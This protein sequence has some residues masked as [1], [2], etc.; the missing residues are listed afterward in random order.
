MA[1]AATA[2]KIGFDLVSPE[3]LLLS[4]DV[5][6]VEIPAE[7]GDIGVLAGHAPMIV[8]LR[9]GIIRIHEGGEVTQRLFVSGGFCE[10]TPQR[11]TVLA[12]EATP[13][14]E[15]DRVRAEARVKEAEAAY[16]A[17]ARADEATREAAFAR[18]LSAQAMVAAAGR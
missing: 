12:D 1:Q 6:L 11:C 9:G 18:L 4:A 17:A 2:G 16:Q 14:D 8:N 15:L 5:D 3:K 7:E 13:A 10:V